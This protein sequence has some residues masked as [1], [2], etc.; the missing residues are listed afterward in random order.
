MPSALV[1]EPG[2]Q[3]MLAPAAR[4]TGNGGTAHTS[5][6]LVRGAAAVGTAV[7]TAFGATPAPDTAVGAAGQE[8]GVG[9]RPQAVGYLDRP[10]LGAGI[11]R[12]R[13]M[14]FGLSARYVARVI[15]AAAVTAGA[16]V[17]SAPLP[18]ASAQPCSDIEVV[19]AR[20][21]AEPP[22]V[23]GVGQSFVDAVRAQAGGKSVAVYPVNYAASADFGDRI[24][25]AT[26]FVDGIRDAGNHVQATAANCP[27]TRIVLGGF[28]QGAAVAGFV[29][30]AS[31][32]PEIPPEFRPFIPNPMPPEVAD[33]VATVALFG[34]PSEQFLRDVGA[35]PVVI[36]PLYADKTIDLCAADDTICNGAPVGGPSIAHALYGVNGMVGQAASFAI[37]RV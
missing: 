26:S 4:P 18:V 8:P 14:G 23:G 20:G 33:H 28:S 25:F 22:G 30:S 15:G 9:S 21:T 1:M 6:A 24:G 11:E 19:F 17:I 32:P 12:I 36:G 2:D 29:T 34:K 3:R 27:D 37:D 5:P 7:G 16:M 35:P 13:N 31:I 10:R